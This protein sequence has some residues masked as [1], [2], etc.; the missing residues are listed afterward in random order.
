MTTFNC[1]LIFSS[2]G[3]Q[4]GKNFKVPLDKYSSDG[5]CLCINCC[6][7][8]SINFDVIANRETIN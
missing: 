8:N 1:Y 7:I 3:C 2:R 6:N 4:E 5:N